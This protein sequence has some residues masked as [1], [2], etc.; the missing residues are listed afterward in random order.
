MLKNLRKRFNLEQDFD[1]LFSSLP[2]ASPNKFSFDRFPKGVDNTNID[3]Y[4]CP[5][6]T[7]STRILVRRM[8]LHEIGE[9]SWGEP[10]P[11]PGVRDLE[12][13]EKA[14]TGVME[15]GVSKARKESAPEQIQL[16]HFAILK[17]LLMSVGE[18][19]LQHRD[20]LQNART[21]DGDQ[22]G[23]NAVHL[24]DKLVLLAQQE[25]ALKYRI[26]RKLF[27]H[28]YKLESTTLRKLRKS[29]LGRS[30]PVPKEVLFNP[31]LQLPSLWVEDQFMHHYPLAMMRKHD[32]SRFSK[33]NAMVT[34]MFG[35]FLPAW[36]HALQPL[37]SEDDISVLGRDSAGMRLRHDRGMLPGFLEAEMLLSG[38]VQEDE[39]AAGLSSWLD[40]PHNMELILSLKESGKYSRKRHSQRMPLNGTP[41]QW[42]ALSRQVLSEVRR[43]LKQAG[44]INA[45]LASHEAPKVYR[46]LHGRVPLGL[47]CQYLEGEI[48]R[49]KLLPKLSAIKDVSQPEIAKK[50][51]EIAVG[52]IQ[53][54]SKSR[55]DYRIKSFLL[56]FS[57]LRRDMKLAYQTHCAMNGIK[58]LLRDETIA[59]SRSNAS[60][61]E[62]IQHPND[63]EEESRIKNH[64]IVK[65]DVRGSTAITSE[66]IDQRLNP[67]THFSLNF[68]Q[69]INQQLDS[70]GATKVFVEGDAIILS[71]AEYE[72]APYQWL[73]VSHA[74]GLASKIL[75][76]VDKQNVQNRKHGLPE[77]EIGLGISFNDGAPAFLHDGDK[78]IMI[79]PAI[80]RADRLSS[81]S[82]VLRKTAL[83][84]Q[85]KRGV[86]LVIPV[87]KNAMDKGRSDELLGYNVNGIE[88]DMPAFFKLK[89]EL[90][91]LR[92][93]G[94]V[95]GY[96]EQSVF[97]AGRYPDRIGKMHWLVV[98][99][100]PVRMWIGNTINT[101]E[102]WGRRFYEV[103]TNANVIAVLK[104]RII[105][106]RSEDGEE[107]SV[108]DHPDG[109]PDSTRYIH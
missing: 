28:V 89:S 108:R 1:D 51:L 65:A 58:I 2:S 60:L 33:I 42:S 90:A 55:S 47:I 12:N 62:F 97:Y 91:L 31:I 67:A 37:E 102:E 6:F 50:V 99:E 68:F 85:V 45:I 56:D 66:L 100:A 98:R 69:P 103:I 86:E 34:D 71:I 75:Q 88:L 27:R 78:Q 82:A 95:P 73:C 92:L 74:C 105:S 19:L 80:N 64:V 70:F 81:C 63:E 40:N 106:S 24:H 101:E 53:N 17:Y 11:P 46:E 79:S 39:Y 83:G 8:L 5:Q 26:T 43:R 9:N 84:E 94:N 107:L 21:M 52:R 109:E 59:L 29:V 87:D 13:F 23:G 76:V 72:D 41:D 7:S 48:P 36:C 44:L 61:Q 32:P 30:W 15:A 4:L 25:V 10:H 3:V 14:Y 20:R 57:V 49:R 96:S 18:E 104:E 77:L 93:G 35:C 22:S 54:I 38:G 16:L